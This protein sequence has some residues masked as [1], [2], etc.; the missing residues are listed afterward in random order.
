MANSE[1]LRV[2]VALPLSALAHRRLEGVERKLQ[3]LC[4]AGVIKWV[5]PS[6]IHLTLFFLGDVMPARL[7]PI[8]EALAVVARNI[9]PFTVTVGGLGVFPN[10]RSPSVLWVGMRDS[11]GQLTLL[12]QVVNEALA[13]VGFE[14]ERRPFT[15][16]LTL[17]RV[18]RNTA[19]QTKSQIGEVLR[20]LNIGQLTTE[21]LTELVLF[22]SELRRSGAVYTRLATFELTG[23]STFS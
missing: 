17:G 19:S 12:H 2:F 18:R 1:T 14:P 5:A 21:E 20:G 15:P 9:P 23:E 22:R 10:P 7:I 8:R 11:A 13:H 6:K 16:H 4:P 3:R